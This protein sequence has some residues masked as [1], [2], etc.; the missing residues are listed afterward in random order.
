MNFLQKTYK[1]LLFLLNM[2]KSFSVSMFVLFLSSLVSAQ[3]NLASGLGKGMTQLI[4]AVE[5]MLG[6]FF[7]VI[8]GGSADMLFEKILFLA[9]I[10]AIV[11]TIISKMDIFKDNKVVIW[12]VSISVSLLS[13]RFLSGE[14]LRTVLLPYSV[15]GVSISAAL[16]TLIY[17]TF[18]QS[19]KESATVRKTLWIFYMIVFITI[20]SVR[21]NSLGQMS[22][23]YLLSAAAALLFFIFDGTIRRAIV[24]HWMEQLNVNNKSQFLIS[25][26]KELGELEENRKLG[27]I[28]ESDYKKTRKRLKKQMQTIMKN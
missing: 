13:T 1:V 10:L 27:Y 8:L 5:E 21:Y 9:I 14:L 26:R 3:T 28:E 22:F 17:F 7:S 19:F 15:L 25:I 2:K 24:A 18:V 12:I 16:P 20:W 4:D 11:Y 6:P 23:I